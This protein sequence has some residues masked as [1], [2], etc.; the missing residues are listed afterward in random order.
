MALWSLLTVFQKIS[1]VMPE[2]TE[3]SSILDNVFF[4]LKGAVLLFV[5]YPGL[6]KMYYS[7]ATSR[8]VHM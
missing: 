5:P 2:A 4:S 1:S 8:G 7:K 6:W 3:T